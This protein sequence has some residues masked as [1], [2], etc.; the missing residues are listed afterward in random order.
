MSDHQA[1]K[2]NIEWGLEHDGI[3]APLPHDVPMTQ[4]SALA[5]L[6][7]LRDWTGDP[8]AGRIVRRTVDPWSPVLQSLSTPPTS[9][10]PGEGSR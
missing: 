2:D 5:A 3:T 9:T 4:A 1:E 8:T 7:E 6:A 10:T